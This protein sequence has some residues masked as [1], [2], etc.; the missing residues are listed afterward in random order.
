MTGTSPRYSIGFEAHLTHTVEE[1]DTARHWGN[2]VPVLATPILL[3]LSELASMRITDDALA[4]NGKMTV[5]THHD[6]AHLAPTV[7]GEQV[8]VR[9][10]L[11]EQT[12]RAL[13]FDVEAHDSRGLVLRGR[14]RRGIIDRS[15]F[16]AKVHA[17]GHGAPN[18][19]Q[20]PREHS[21]HTA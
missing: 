14:H 5:G 2:D 10:T 13:T 8:T 4:A 21:V 15:R 18:A 19:D 3:W 1:K 20:H 16:L 11:I 17:L 9:A 6:T 12:D 7:Q